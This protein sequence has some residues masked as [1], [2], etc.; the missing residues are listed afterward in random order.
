MKK[1]LFAILIIFGTLPIFSQEQSSKGLLMAGINGAF[2]GSGDEIGICLTTNYD[3]SLN[4]FFAISPRITFGSASSV[5]YGNF[6]HLSSAAISTSLIITP[7]P[8]RFD[9][10]KFEIGALYHRFSNSYGMVGEISEYGTYNSSSTEFYI[11]KLWGLIGSV[12]VNILEN[13]KIVTGVRGDM[14]TSFTEAYFNCDSVQAGFFF[15]LKL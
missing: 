12:R 14:L 3:Y 5:G 7:L 10:I 11:E 2:W 4:R 8:A 15:G 13:D 1:L 6:S 9:N